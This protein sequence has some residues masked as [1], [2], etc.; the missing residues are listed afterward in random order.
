MQKYINYLQVLN[1]YD[2]VSLLNQ[3]GALNGYKK[4]KN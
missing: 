2:I 1:N 4:S 3:I